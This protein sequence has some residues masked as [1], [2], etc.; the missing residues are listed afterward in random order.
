MK[1]NLFLVATDINVGPFLS[2]LTHSSDETN[3]NSPLNNIQNTSIELGKS[4]LQQDEAQSTMNPI[5]V[6]NLKRSHL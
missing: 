1:K 2:A 3:S 5:S 6:D 4:P